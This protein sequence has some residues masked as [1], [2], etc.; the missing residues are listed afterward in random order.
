MRDNVCLDDH[1]Q[2]GHVPIR[3]DIKKE[4]QNTGHELLHWKMQEKKRYT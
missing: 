1:V 3:I 2:V 4:L